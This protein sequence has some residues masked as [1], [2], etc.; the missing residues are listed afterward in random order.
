MKRL[1]KSNDKKIS[2][3]CAGFA[4]YFEVD[5]T[6]IRLLYVA[7]LLVNFG[8]FFLTYIIFAFIMPSPDQSHL[9]TA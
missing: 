4:E 8:A 9:K 7:C 3:V 2:G 5:P 6:A 1:T